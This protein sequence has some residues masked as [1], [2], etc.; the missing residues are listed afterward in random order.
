MKKKVLVTG[1]A[2]FIGSHLCKL[3]NNKYK[4]TV[5]DNFS[6]SKKHNL[7]KSAE[8]LKKDI[9]NFDS[10]IAACKNKDI[11]FHLA[12]KVS[13]RNSIKTFDDDAKNNIMGTTNILRAA[14]ETG[15]KKIK[16]NGI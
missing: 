9:C 11:V 12:A 6:Q 16:R 7:D 5:I 1:G 14:A 4:V 3:L 8:I 2:G 15:V 10:C 13:V